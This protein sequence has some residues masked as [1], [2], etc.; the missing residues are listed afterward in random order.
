[1]AP[2]T[3]LSGSTL[4]AERGGGLYW[5]A[6]AVV[7]ALVTALAGAWVMLVEILR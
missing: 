1:V 3:V 4:I 6:P 5:V 2:L 7:V